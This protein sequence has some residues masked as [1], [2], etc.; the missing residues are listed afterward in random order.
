MSHDA[1]K[2]TGLIPGVKLEN[3]TELIIGIYY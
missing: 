1:K 2:I 3:I